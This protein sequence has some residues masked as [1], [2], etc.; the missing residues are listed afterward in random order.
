MPEPLQP[1]AFLP[2]SVIPHLKL[3]DRGY[4]TAGPDGLKLLANATK[5]RKVPPRLTSCPRPGPAGRKCLQPWR[6][7]KRGLVLLIT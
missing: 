4:V 1:L 7:L 5:P 6:A 2:L 3:T